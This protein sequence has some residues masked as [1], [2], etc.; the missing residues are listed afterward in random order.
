MV[1][2]RKKR[3]IIAKHDSKAF[4]ITVFSCYKQWLTTQ[5]DI[6]TNTKTKYKNVPAETQ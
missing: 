4:D 3:S 1:N 2:V 6:V 5:N